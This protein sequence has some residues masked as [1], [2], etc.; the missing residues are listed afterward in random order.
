[1]PI[2][3][4]CACGKRYQAVDDLAGKVTKCP[5]CGT[6][7]RVPVLATSATKPTNAPTAPSTA[8]KL[9]SQNNVSPAVRSIPRGAVAKSPAQMAAAYGGA[10][11]DPPGLAFM[12]RDS[13]KWAKGVLITIGILNTVVNLF[14]LLTADGDYMAFMQRFMDASPYIRPLSYVGVALGPVFIALGIWAMSNPLPP[15]IIGF[16][17][18]Q[19][20]AIANFIVTVQATPVRNSSNLVCWSAGV[21]IG[22]V[23][24][25]VAFIKA[26]K[27]GIKHRRLRKTRTR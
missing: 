18:N 1:M 24:I 12:L 9:L 27:G 16:V 26:I 22:E 17:L 8:A 4:S 23:A 3:V 20:Y 21:L 2:T 25:I 10:A 15:A 13:A 14:A 7:V 11:K 19:T 6:A 5:T